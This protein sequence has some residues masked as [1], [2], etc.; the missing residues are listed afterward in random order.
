VALVI[1]VDS[2]SGDCQKVWWLA[3][4]LAIA[5]ERMASGVL[6]GTRPAG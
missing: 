6:S 5:C 4:H 1:Y 3:D 2:I